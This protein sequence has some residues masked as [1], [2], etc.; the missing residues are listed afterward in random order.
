MIKFAVTRPKERLAAINHGVS[1]LKWNTDPY[2]G[3]YGIK[4]DPNMTIVG[5]LGFLPTIQANVI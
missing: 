4:I 3:H 5:H 2:L 1:M